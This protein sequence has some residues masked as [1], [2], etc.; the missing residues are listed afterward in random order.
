VSYPSEPI[1]ALASRNYKNSWKAQN[2][3]SVLLESLRH[4]LLT[5]AIAQGNRG[6]VMVHVLHLWAI[7]KLMRDEIIHGVH[8]V[9]LSKYL[10]C[11]SREAAPFSPE[12]LLLDP[13]VPL[14]QVLLEA[15]LCFTHFVPLSTG[16]HISCIT[17]DLLRY[18]YRRTAALATANGREGIDWII[19]L[20]VGTDEFIGLVG[21]DKN[22]V[23]DTLEDLIQ[24]E[25]SETDSMLL[26][27]SFLSKD[28]L[29]TFPS[30]W[31]DVQW[32]S[33][34]FAV[35]SKT[36]GAALTRVR[37]KRGKRNLRGEEI[38]KRTIE[39]PFPC[40]VF[41][42]LDF[43]FFSDEENAQ[44]K[45]LRDFVPDVPARVKKCTPLTYNGSQ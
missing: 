15:K 25:G 38:V 43:S 18:A 11:F 26:P 23:S 9:K 16:S 7:D 31:R 35:D 36:P 37:D 3:G 4:F 29:A 27:T 33:I 12:T 32:P 2:F 40:I 28:E 44:L 39:T 14:M 21:Q 34:L 22:P 8:E 24:I 42:G 5:G 13:T 17:H 45:Q 30:Q 10:E 1:L 41:T 20:R 6:E 19:P